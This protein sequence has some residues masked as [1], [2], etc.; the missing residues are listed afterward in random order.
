MQLPFS[1]SLV[2]FVISALFQGPV[3]V[4]LLFPLSLHSSASMA[5]LQ[6][7]SL[8][9]M[10]VAVE[11]PFLAAP[12]LQPVL[13]HCQL[14]LR[15]FYFKARNQPTFAVNF[16]HPLKYTLLLVSYILFS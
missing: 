15:H 1:F 7:H 11:S 8:A 14:T 16:H 5:V 6:P 2:T 12:S 13:K 9:H 4:T 3:F 10:H